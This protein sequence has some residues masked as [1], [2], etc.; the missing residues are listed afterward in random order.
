MFNKFF[1][2]LSLVCRIPF[3][4]HG[5]FDLSRADAYLPIVGVFPAAIAGLTYWISGAVMK[6]GVVPV[7]IMLI[8]QYLS[9]N[10]FHLDG[11][12]DTADAFLGD[13]NREKRFAVLK[14]SRVGVYGLFAAF[15]VLSLKA[16]LFWELLIPG[17][18]FPG[19][20]LNCSINGRFAA[21]LIPCMTVPAKP[22]GLGALL[23]DASPLRAAGGTVVG[24]CL[25]AV[26][27]GIFYGLPVSSG[28]GILLYVLFY[29]IPPFLCVLVAAG[30][31]RMYRNH[32]GGYTGDALGAAVELGE[33]AHLAAVLI[34]SR[35]RGYL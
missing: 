4:V 20:V 12:A 16:G 5:T 6:E 35:L 34:L 30:I 27:S 17:A 31:A 29:L 11:L 26:F 33:L 1:S 21:I 3:K 19:A 9:F 10:L 23:K 2:T 14:D 28:E 7:L 15:A 18:V 24:L 8:V 25:W 22:D 32:L 13:F